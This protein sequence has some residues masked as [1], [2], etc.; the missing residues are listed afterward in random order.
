MRRR[1]RRRQSL[2]RPRRA[3]AIP[4]ALDFAAVI[5]L[6]L[7]VGGAA[8]AIVHLQ[9]EKPTMR[10]ARRRSRSASNWRRCAVK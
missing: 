7:H 2:D 10:L 1:K 9:T 6:A 8:L 3:K 5:A 4:A